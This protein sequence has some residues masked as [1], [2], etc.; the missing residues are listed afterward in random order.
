M[1]HLDTVEIYTG[2][3]ISGFEKNR[4]DTRVLVRVH[5][6]LNL[7]AQQIKDRHPNLHRVRDAVSDGRE[8][9]KGIGIG[10]AEGKGIAGIW[11]ERL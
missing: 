5:E 2:R 6:S 11:D 10:V 7:T 3:Q 8:S 1:I 9:L 4:V